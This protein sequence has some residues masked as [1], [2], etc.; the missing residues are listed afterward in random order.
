MRYWVYIND[1]V[2]GPFDENKLVTL[3][4]FSQ[5]T[6]ICS[7]EVA[8]NGGQEW[9]KASSI[10]EF[11]EVP[12]EE[13][14]AV[15]TPDRTVRDIPAAVTHEMD[16]SILLAKLD[17]L[18][19]EL[20]YLHQKINSMQTHLDEALEQNKQLANQAALQAQAN[21]LADMGGT[22]AANTITLSSTDKEQEPKEEP[23]EEENPHQKGESLFANQ[24]A[25][26]EEELIIRSAL[27]SIY[28]EKL[29]TPKPTAT[30]TFQ[31]LLPEKSMEKEIAKVEQIEKELTF[32]PVEESAE[33]EGVKE[34]ALITTPSAE[35]A[36]RDELI[37]E[38]TASPKEDILDQIIKEH[39]T[40][41]ET[42]KSSQP[43]EESIAP[44]EEKDSS[45]GTAAAIGAAA[46][47][48]AGIAAA[49]SAETTKEDLP[50]DEKEV[51]TSSQETAEETSATQEVAE[52]APVIQETA[53]ETPAVAEENSP[54]E[55]DLPQEQSSDFSAST[56]TEK[57][58]EEPA[59]QSDEKAKPFFMATDKNDPSHVE[60]VLPADQLPPD[61][62]QEVAPAADM[63][64]LPQTADDSKSSDTPQVTDAAPKQPEQQLA[65]LDSLEEGK[66]D[67]FSEELV[68]MFA[69]KDPTQTVEELVP[70]KSLEK[71]PLLSDENATGPA[72][73]LTEEDLENAF[74]PQDISIS[75]TSIEIPE[76]SNPNDLTEIEL[77]EGSTYLISDFVPP[78]QVT[79]E[80]SE[81]MLNPGDDADFINKKQETII[82][83]M[84]AVTNKNEQTQL[85]STEGLPDDAVAS[86]ISLENTIQAKRGASL[87]IKTVPMVPEPGDAQRLN[88]DELNDINAQHDKTSYKSGKGLAKIVIGALVGVLL[89]II[90]YVALGLFNLLPSSVNLF[91]KPNPAA[92]QTAAEELLSEEEEETA[93]PA[94]ENESEELTPADEALGKVQNFPLP[95]GLTLK[96]FV[97][98]K[99]AGVPADLI[100][101]ESVDA[102]EPDNYS[103]TVKVPPENPQNFKTVYRFNYN[104]QSGL[105][106]PTISDAKNLLDQAYGMTKK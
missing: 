90:L 51:K 2:D 46:A 8:S 106:D 87:D 77:K 30:E 85:L 66:S 101:W 39:Q 72:N 100:T 24:A 104:M 9:V 71:Q 10:F 38:L 28:G 25:P 65:S 42:E 80:A 81:G 40:E 22:A 18:T 105:L 70:G 50:A 15:G 56:E 21:L 11:D 53:Q 64:E 59:V 52:E 3:S 102:V 27:D 43:Q 94:Q 12:V 99:H 41:Q 5:D 96:Q 1:K 55:L 35:E 23:K 29:I 74:D 68:P 67:A 95:N 4:G 93:L 84:L 6:L 61:T 13:A 92:A 36:A 69:E 34:E 82:Q 44:T 33:V 37:N 54:L 78:A 19:E 49:A 48:I 76:N 7:E 79:D 98:A 17:S 103:I 16:S 60:E 31:D 88:V 86:K 20:S 91:S 89:L 58:Q 26:K 73:A 32:F 83:D 62:P 45:L 47:A 97:E 14:P 57:P 75:P 63:Q